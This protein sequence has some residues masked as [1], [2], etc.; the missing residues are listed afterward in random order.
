MWEMETPMIAEPPSI[1]PV[2]VVPKPTPTPTPT[3]SPPVIVA[4]APAP[5]PPI[6]KESTSIPNVTGGYVVGSF[7]IVNPEV[8]SAQ[9]IVGRYRFIHE[10]SFD[11]SPEYHLFKLT[12]EKG[13]YATNFRFG[14]SYGLLDTE[15]LWEFKDWMT[16]IPEKSYPLEDTPIEFRIDWKGRLPYPEGEIVPTTLTPAKAP[17]VTLP[18]N[19]WL[20]IVIIAGIVV[21]GLVIYFLVRKRIKAKG[22]G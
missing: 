21:L 1:P 5:P 20:I 9:G 10:Y 8:P 4:P 6:V 22:S 11:Q 17:S 16:E 12:G 18:I 3:P 19:L 7:D 2:I 14:H 13:Y 15:S